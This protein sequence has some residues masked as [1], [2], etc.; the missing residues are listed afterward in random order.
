MQL[1]EALRYKMAGIIIFFI[2]IHQVL[3]KTQ[4]AFASSLQVFIT[5][6]DVQYFNFFFFCMKESL[7]QMNL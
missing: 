6:F 5:L 1:V 4:E 2:F 3:F 7:L